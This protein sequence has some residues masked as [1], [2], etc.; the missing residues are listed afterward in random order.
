MSPTASGILLQKNKAALLKNKEWHLFFF[1]IFSVRLLAGGAILERR[2]F[3]E[4]GRFATSFLS[5]TDGGLALPQVVR[6]RAKGGD[7]DRTWVPYTGVRRPPAVCPQG[8]TVA[9][10]GGETAR[11]RD[12]EKR[13]S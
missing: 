1:H 2:G 5:K 3:G 7:G 10:T 11:Q 12:S 9:E 13:E 6:N 4:L 8:R